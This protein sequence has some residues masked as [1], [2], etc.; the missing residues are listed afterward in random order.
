VLLQEIKLPA[1]VAAAIETKNVAKQENAAYDYRLQSAAKEAQRKQIEARGIKA[2]QDTVSPGLTDNYLLWSGIQAT[3]GLANS[4]NSKIIV[5]GSG[6]GGLPLILGNLDDGKMGMPAPPAVPL[7]APSI[8]GGIARSSV[9]EA[10]DARP[11][12][13][14]GS[15]DAQQGR[16]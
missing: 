2:V 1:S 11:Q 7:P 8:D 16:R 4:P 15:T 12:G 10:T 9:P 13:K 14:I 5:F 3:N 6:K